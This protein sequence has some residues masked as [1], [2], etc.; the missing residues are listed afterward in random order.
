MPEPQQPGDR[1]PA[2]RQ[3]DHASLAQLSETLVPAIVA[4]LTGSG[5]GEVEVREGDWRIRVRRPLGGA[6]SAHARRTERPRLGTQAAHA[7]PRPSKAPPL[8]E[9]ADPDRAVATSP[10]VGVFRPGV[11]LGTAVHAGDR[12]ATI[13]LLGIAQDVTS[14]I[15]GTLVELFV[16]AGEAVEYGE[17]IGAIEA[18]A[19]TAPADEPPAAA[20]GEG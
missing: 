11:S 12:I 10:A 14:P 19:P 3:A 15:D 18:E 2:Q 5:L 4:K 20:T 8:V 7:E 9:P 16:Q 1:T 13:D 6:A 17:E